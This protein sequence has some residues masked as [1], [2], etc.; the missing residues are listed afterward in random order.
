LHGHIHQNLIDEPEYV[1]NCVEHTN[2][3]PRSMDEIKDLI[4]HR[5]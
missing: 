3:S 4:R 1:N 2:Y 5:V